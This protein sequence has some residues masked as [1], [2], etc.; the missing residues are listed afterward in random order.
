MFKKLLAA[1]AVM[2]AFAPTLAFPDAVIGIDT[3]QSMY[4]A[5]YSPE[6]VTTNRRMANFA[7]P[8]ARV[9]DIL[10]QTA[11]AHGENPDLILRLAK[12][13]S[14]YNPRAMG[15]RLREGDRAMGLLQVRVASANSLG[16]TGSASELLK[17]EV[18]AYWGVQHVK[19]CRKAGALTDDQVAEC[20]VGGPRAL[21]RGALRASAERYKRQYVAMFRS[22][23][24]DPYRGWLSRGNGSLNVATLWN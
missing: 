20:H 3:A 22:A 13:E 14:S 12:I 9:R 19:M 21:R 16:F 4:I 7:G 17:P 24:I 6:P 1:L 8:S 11:K 18:G 5:A 2:I 23:K 15:P 10:I